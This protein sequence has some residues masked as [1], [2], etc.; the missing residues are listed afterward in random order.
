MEIQQFIDSTSKG[1]IGLD[2][3]TA[4]AATRAAHGDDVIAAFRS[5]I[6]LRSTS[7]QAVLD[8]AEKANRDTLLASEQR[9]YDAAIRERDSILRLQQAVEARTAQAAHVPATQVTTT[10]ETTEAVGPVLTREQPVARF[11]EQRG[12]ALYASERGAESMRLGR[13]IRALAFGDRRGLSDL[14]RRAL[15]EGSDSSGGYTVPEIVAGRFI[16][17]VRNAMV[18]SRAGALI[19]PMTSDTLHLAR[20]G[21]PDSVSPAIAT[22]TWKAENADIDETDAT[23]ERVTFTARTLPVLIRMS[24]ELGE[25]SLNID[26]II[27]RELAAQL[28][29]ELDRA[30]LLGSGSAPEPRGIVNQSGVATTAFGGSDPTSYDFMVDA[31]GRLWALNHEPNGAIYNA[32]LATL[33]AKLKEGGSSNQPLRAPDV[34][35]ALAKHR[36]NTIPNANTSPNSTTMIV[37][38]FSQLLIGLRTSFRLEV[39]RVAANAFEKL[40]IVTRAYLRA[41]VQLAHPEAFDVTTGIGI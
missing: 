3:L 4:I 7:A 35:A 33:A 18:T 29:L 38:D 39:S 1:P 9:S 10:T 30:A 15:A 28:A 36:T 16:D 17:R 20:L 26:E 6:E 37:G 2:V 34:V 11:I 31:I 25:D 24:V 23:L 32:S 27:E 13:H 19:V 8:A 12:G 41:D 40:Q 5:Q 22:A 21:Q 14:D